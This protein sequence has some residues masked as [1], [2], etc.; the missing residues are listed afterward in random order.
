[1]CVTIFKFKKNLLFKANKIFSENK[2]RFINY[3]YFNIQYFNNL[4]FK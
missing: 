4:I 1:M 3:A 2:I